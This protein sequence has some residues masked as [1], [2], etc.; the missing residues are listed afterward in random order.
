M[1]PR[2]V[3]GVME[4]G[5]TE[6]RGAVV[7][8]RGSAGDGHFSASEMQMISRSLRAKTQRLANAG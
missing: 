3:R 5:T 1:T 2:I 7:A 8:L 6:E 4:K